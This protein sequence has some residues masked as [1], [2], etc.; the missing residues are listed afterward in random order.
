MKGAERLITGRTK[1]AVVI[2]DPIDHSLSPVI[3][4]AGFAS[5]NVD[6]TY[7][8]MRLTA[9][10]LDSFLS[11]VRDGAI[12]GA[13]VTMPHKAA[14]AAS[15]D[16]LDESASTLASVNTVVRDA[17][18][19]VI[20]HSTDGDGLCDGLEEAGF[21]VTGSSV[22]VL[23]A[24]GAAR[25][26]VDALARHDVSNIHVHNRT[27]S[28]AEML[29]PLARGRGHLCSSDVLADVVGQVD[30]VINAT[31]VG[32]GERVSPLREGLLRA[33]Q[34]EVDIV[35]HP[36]DTELLRQAR[37]VGC[38]TVDGLQMLIHQAVRQQMLWTGVRPDVKAMT[39][40]A[41]RAL[42]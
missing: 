32:M 21:S 30:I 31:N 5:T 10:R 23:G 37:Q 24:G 42:G 3:H 18:G 40:A 11:L 12:N 6:W 27:T 34:L 7:A 1:L 29:V 20:G 8:A 9:E 26:I 33:D 2:G 17:D 36:L 28:R 22:L 14:V 41:V 35:Y 16:R 19:S 13:S 4:N 38:A 15:V 25:S 39:L